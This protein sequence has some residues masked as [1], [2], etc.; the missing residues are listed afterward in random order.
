MIYL[1]SNAPSA[2]CPAAV[3]SLL[4]TISPTPTIN[5]MTPQIVCGGLNT[6]TINF[7]GTTGASYSWVNSNTLIGLGSGPTSATNIPAFATTNNSSVQLATITVTPSLGACPGAP[8]TVFITINPTPD[9]NPINDTIL[10]AGDSLNSYLF[11]GSIPGSNFNG[12][13]ILLLQQPQLD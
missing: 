9:I 4:L 11:N 2:F 3:D 5:A 8:E 7:T 13:Q 10:C 12:L 1:T 6:T